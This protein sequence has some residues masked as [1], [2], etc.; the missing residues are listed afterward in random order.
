[1][2]EFKVDVIE[3]VTTVNLTGRIDSI[4]VPLFEGKCEE[5]KTS[6]GKY[7]LNF[8]EVDFVSSRGL[9]ALIEFRKAVVELD[10]AMAMVGLSDDLQDLLFTVGLTHLFTVRPSLEDGL[11]YLQQASQPGELDS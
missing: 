10:G 3:D 1:M 5:L 2:L 11:R 6:K 4:S 7:L 9:W 8:S